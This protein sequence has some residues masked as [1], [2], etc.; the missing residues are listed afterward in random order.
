MLKLHRFS[1]VN[2]SKRLKVFIQSQTQKS[3]VIQFQ[4]IRATTIISYRF[5]KQKRALKVSNELTN[6]V[7][8]INLEHQFIYVFRK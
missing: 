1:L 7:F 6:A 4:I 3:K 5:R 2:G 8:S